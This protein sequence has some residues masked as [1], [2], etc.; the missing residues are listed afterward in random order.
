MGI[1]DKIVDK[2]S[3]DSSSFSRAYTVLRARKPKDIFKHKLSDS[4]V[5]LYKCNINFSIN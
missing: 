5:K 2:L 3:W 1:K 4:I